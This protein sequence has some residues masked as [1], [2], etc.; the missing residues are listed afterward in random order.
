MERLEPAVEPIECPDT[1]SKISMTQKSK[2][3]LNFSTKAQ[4]KERI[5]NEDYS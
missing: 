4:E 2:I 5:F 1:E 3:S